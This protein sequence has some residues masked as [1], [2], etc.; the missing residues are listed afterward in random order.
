MNLLNTASTRHGTLLAC[1]GK[2]YSL[3]LDQDSHLLLD[4]QIASPV[5]ESPAHTPLTLVTPTMMLR[6][7]PEAFWRAF[8][9]EKAE[10]SM[11]ETGYWFAQTLLRQE[12]LVQW[13]T[14]FEGVMQ[15]MT[16]T[17]APALPFITLPQPRLDVFT[18]ECL[19]RCDAHPTL[20]QVQALATLLQQ[21]IETVTH[22]L[23][24]RGKATATPFNEQEDDEQEPRPE[25]SEVEASVQPLS[26]AMRSSTR[27][28]SARTKPG[29]FKWTDERVALLRTAF[30]ALPASAQYSRYAAAATIARQ[31]NWPRQS[32][33][34]K[35]YALF[36]R[37]M[38]EAEPGVEVLKPGSF[39][40]D[41]QV[42]QT[43][44][45]AQHER[46][47]LDFPLGSFPYALGSIVKYRG[48]RYEVQQAHSNLLVMRSIHMPQPSVPVETENQ[49]ACVL[50]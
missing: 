47:E 48:Q 22:W 10:P 6:C 45:A 28:A 30:A 43:D 8:A 18:E 26:M 19:T 33:E 27:A 1:D 39:L 12:Q 42:Q 20:A 46:W 49:K 13:K 9:G 23:D 16:E 15:Q 7:T 25:A 11:E 5:I 14:R 34:Y 24:E 44:E 36:P 38:N 35:L 31:C 17:L 41:V 29:Q 21:D 32:V 3:A 37:S 4:G 50:A 2:T 40:W